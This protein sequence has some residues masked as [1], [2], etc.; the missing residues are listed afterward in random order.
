MNLVTACLI[1]YYVIG[2]YV[3]YCCTLAGFGLSDLDSPGGRRQQ[4]RD[5]R[6]R[7]GRGGRRPETVDPPPVPRSDTGL[8]IGALNIQSLKPKLL[9]LTD[10]ISRNNYDVLLLSETWL[11]P[12]T[13]NRLLVIPGYFNRTDNLTVGATAVSPSSPRQASRPCL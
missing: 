4:R 8:L 7:R 10:E 5:A 3:R 9:E 2:A 12:S 6:G 13:P 1:V 11:R